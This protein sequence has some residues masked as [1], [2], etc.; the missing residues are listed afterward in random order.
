V[1]S[2]ESIWSHAERRFSAQRILG[3]PQRASSAIKVCIYSHDTFGLG[4]LRRNLAIADQLLRSEHRFEVWLLTGSPVIRQW[5]LPAGLHVQPLPPVVKT[6]ADRYASRMPGQMFGLTKGYREALIMRLLEEQRPD[7]FLVDHAPAGMNGELLST[8]ALIRNEMPRTRTVLGLRDILDGPAVV[9]ETWREQEIQELIE[10]GYDDVLVYGSERLFDV[11][12]AYGL[13]PSVA[14]RTKYCGY[15]VGRGRWEALAARSGGQV[16][17]DE[18][19]AGGLPV[20]LVTAG[21]GGDGF[22]LM[23]AYLRSLRRGGPNPFHSVVVTGPLMPRELYARLQAAAGP[24]AD[25]QLVSYTTDLMPSVRA[26]SLI[27]S[28]AGYNT[29]VELLAAR[30]NAIVVPRS[31]PREEQRLRAAMLSRL[32]LVRY[33]EA[34]G[35]LAGRLAEL[36][37]Q[38]LAGPPAGEDGW[39]SIDLRGAERVVEH[40]VE[41]ASRR[42]ATL[43]MGGVA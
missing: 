40:L 43:G 34:D 20:V 12:E 13:R 31:A 37:P 8:L 36:V 15:I 27:V 3:G 25:V 35:D 24:R 29:S 4:H 21:G 42:D 38:A 17:W 1:E 2:C 28:M 7:V 26:A 11:V 18:R 6:G 41:V 23:D 19:R 9:R 5:T 32:G 33:A 22:F 16:C 30:K 39:A 10:H 14:R